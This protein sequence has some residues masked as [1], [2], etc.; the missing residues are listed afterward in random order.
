M[1]TAAT[2]MGHFP[3]VLAN[4]PGAGARNSIG[5][6]LVSG[7]VIGSFF[8]LFVVP[9]VYLVVARD[10]G[11]VASAERAGQGPD[12]VEPAGASSLTFE[13]A[14]PWSDQESRQVIDSADLP[15]ISSPTRK[16]CGRRRRHACYAIDGWHGAPGE[17]FAPFGPRKGTYACPRLRKSPSRSSC[18]STARAVGAASRLALSTAS[19][20]GPR[21][22]PRRGSSRSSSTSRTARP[23]ACA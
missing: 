19:S 7:M 11:R 12:L 21:S 22:T 23:A 4:G 2:V 13:L 5:I 9:A 16:S 15:P 6:M 3:L 10:H 1:T 18:R 14:P 8:T 17:D 20:S